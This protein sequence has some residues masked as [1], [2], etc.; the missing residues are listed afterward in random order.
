[1]IKYGWNIKTNLLSKNF[2]FWKSENFKSFNCILELIKIKLMGWNIYD[3]FMRPFKK[4]CNLA[5][6]TFRKNSKFAWTSSFKKHWLLNFFSVIARRNMIFE[7]WK[8]LNF[9]IISRCLK[10]DLRDVLLRSFNND[11]IAPSLFVKNRNW[12]HPS[13][14]T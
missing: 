11:P 14:S 13:V 12:S 8:K 1:M 2:F 6:F 3:P 9:D 7:M 5:F 10:T 4:Y